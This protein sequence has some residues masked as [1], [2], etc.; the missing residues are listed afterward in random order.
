MSERRFWL[1]EISCCAGKTFNVNAFQC[2]EGTIETIGTCNYDPCYPD[3][4]QYGSCIASQSSGQNFQCSCYPGWTGEICDKPE[5]GII[6]QNGGI[7]EYK[8]GDC[9]C[10]CPTGF[11]GTYCELDP[12]D[13]IYCENGASPFIMK[14]G[15]CSCQCP[16]GFYGDKCEFSP[17]SIEPC[18]GNGNCQ[19]SGSGYICECIPGHSG[20]TCDQSICDIGMSHVRGLLDQCGQHGTC[21]I[22]NDHWFQELLSK[23]KIINLYKNR[24]KDDF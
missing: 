6:C 1:A 17:C 13:N 12:C 4:C 5:C 21:T 7:A 19:I 24:K 9:Q 23:Y 3:P 22:L 15:I 2:C 20:P 11:T 16:P 14:T 18:G 10:T 8:N